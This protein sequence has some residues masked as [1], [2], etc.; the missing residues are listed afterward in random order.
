MYLG[1]LKHFQKNLEKR[2]DEF[3][4]RTKN[5]KRLDH[6][7]TQINKDTYRIPGDIKALILA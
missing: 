2:H 7:T 5:S 3:E 4:I 6:S 1:L